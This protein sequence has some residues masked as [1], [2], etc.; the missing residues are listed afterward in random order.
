MTITVTGSGAAGNAHHREGERERERQEEMGEER[1]SLYRG[2]GRGETGKDLRVG[3]GGGLDRAPETLGMRNGPGKESR[4]GGNPERRGSDGKSRSL[5]PW[6]MNVSLVA[7]LLSIL[8]YIKALS[9][10][11]CPT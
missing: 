10:P 6:I 4:A 3:D 7:K 11:L 5:P 9:S 1:W 2:G 8:I